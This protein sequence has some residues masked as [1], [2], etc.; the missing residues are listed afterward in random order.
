MLNDLLS[1]S[2]KILDD[3]L[4]S[5]EEFLSTNR[6]ILRMDVPGEKVLF[7]ESLGGDMLSLS[8]YDRDRVNTGID[9]EMVVR[10]DFGK[11]MVEA[12][13]FQDGYTY[14]Y[15]YIDEERCHEDVKRELNKNLNMWLKELYSKGFRNG[16]S[17]LWVGK[18]VKFIVMG[19][20]GTKVYY[21]EVVYVIPGGVA[22]ET[23]IVEKYYGEKYPVGA[24]RAIVAD[25]IVIKKDNDE[26]YIVLPIKDGRPLRCEYV[27]E[28]I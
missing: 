7:V 11:K 24:L 10:V 6:N 16:N 21:G 5:L 9:M 28:V 3:I 27:L 8:H 14:K 12:L 26:G 2:Y 22:P 1:G 15:V 13:S 20:D 18:N 19:G 23:K 25:R 17:L 4:G